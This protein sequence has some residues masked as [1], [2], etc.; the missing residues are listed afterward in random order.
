M[1]GQHDA[2]WLDRI[3]E[4]GVESLINL[5]FAVVAL[6]LLLV[7][8]SILPGVD[9]LVPG[10]P[11]SYAA[12]LSALV[13]LV[14]SILLV[15]VAWTAKAGIR[16][17]PMRVDE[18]STYAARVVYWTIMFLALVIAYEGLGPAI[19]PLAAEADVLWLYDFAFLAIGIVA[20][21]VVGYSLLRLIDP[22]AEWMVAKLRSEMRDQPSTVQT[23]LPIESA[24][25][26][27][28]E[29]SRW[30]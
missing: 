17:L 23:T 15:R 9:R 2:G 20:I 7:F 6:L 26:R 5:I 19:V 13:T 1:A 29:R 21:F 18:V 10:M 14:I 22:L 30:L 25:E 12:L 28:T 27:E 24:S 4:L 11:I 8:V 3:E 16:Q